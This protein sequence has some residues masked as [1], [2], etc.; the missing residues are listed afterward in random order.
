MKRVFNVVSCIFFL[1]LEGEGKFFGLCVNNR[2][3]DPEQLNPVIL[4]PGS[5]FELDFFLTCPDLNFN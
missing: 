4:P 5:R 3:D 2:G 1:T